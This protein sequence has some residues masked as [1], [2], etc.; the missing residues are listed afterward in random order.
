LGKC[1][2]NHNEP[3]IHEDGYDQKDMIVR[4]GLFGTG[5]SRGEEEDRVMWVNIIKVHELHI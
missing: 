5:R 2:S 1:K 4:V 3:P